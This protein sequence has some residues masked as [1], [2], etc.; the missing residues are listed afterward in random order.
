MTRN[1]VVR[2]TILIA[3]VVFIGACGKGNPSR[4]EI[5]SLI[6]ASLASRRPCAEN[7]PPCVGTPGWIFPLVIAPGDPMSGGSRVLDE[8]VGG[9]LLERADT[10]ATVSAFEFG[11]R[12]SYEKKVPA[13]VYRLT[14]A[15]R[16]SYVTYDHPGLPKVGAFPYGVWK[17]AELRSVSDPAEALGQ[18]YVTAKFTRVL[19]DVPAWVERPGLRA[20]QREI[21]RALTARTV[22][23][24]D[25]IILVKG[26]DG[27]EAEGRA[28]AS[29][30][31]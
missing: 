2:W 9:G 24:A 18:T 5:R 4:E 17:V 20:I 7:G 23:V 25:E 16:R 27:W 19:G 6:D 26:P 14:E 12:G 10:T 11:G 29:D 31:R 21:D 8:L 3:G 28:A 30:Q 15:G 1:R 22:P 13:V